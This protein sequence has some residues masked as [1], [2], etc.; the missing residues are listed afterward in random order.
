MIEEGKISAERVPQDA[1]LP[2]PK[3]PKMTLVE[4]GAFISAML[5]RCTMSGPELR[6]QFAGEAL[7]TLTTDDMLRL[8]TIEQTL[9]VFEQHGADQMVRDKIARRFRR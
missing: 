6:G 2:K 1:E 9:A 3:R 8:E 4:Q 7:L 5:R